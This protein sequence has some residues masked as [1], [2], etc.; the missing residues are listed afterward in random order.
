MSSGLLKPRPTLRVRINKAVNAQRY[1][2]LA[3]YVQ[4]VQANVGVVQMIAAFVIACRAY[5]RGRARHEGGA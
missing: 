1:E 4:A 3:K 5:R 2:S